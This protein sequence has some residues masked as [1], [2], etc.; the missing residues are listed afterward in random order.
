MTSVSPLTTQASTTSQASSEVPTQ[1]SDPLELIEAAVR[2][3][4]EGLEE[5]PERRDTYVQD[6]RD[7]LRQ[8]HSERLL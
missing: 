7:R 2:A 1:F 4:L 8:V 3:C 6:L 5:D